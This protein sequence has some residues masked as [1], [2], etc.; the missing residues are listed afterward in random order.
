MLVAAGHSLQFFG[1]ELDAHGLLQILDLNT[2][3]GASWP[4]YL[5]YYLIE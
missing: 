3:I 1:A 5:S 4:Y 2:H